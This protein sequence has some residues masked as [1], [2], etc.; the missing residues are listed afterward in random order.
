MPR[1]RPAALTLGSLALRLHQDAN[2]HAIQRHLQELGR[3]SLA[4][5]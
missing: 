2:R 3:G 4:V 1:I 5:G